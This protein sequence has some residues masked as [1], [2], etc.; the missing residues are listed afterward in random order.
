MNR[1]EEYLKELEIRNNPLVKNDSGLII[2]RMDKRIG[3]EVPNW[4]LAGAQLDI[5]IW[6][7]PNCQ[8]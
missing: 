2:M 6:N 5:N 8:V 7:R 4:T 1:A 3:L